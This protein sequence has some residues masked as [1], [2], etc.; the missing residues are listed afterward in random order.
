MVDE[1]EAVAK[2]CRNLNHS[3]LGSLILRLELVSRR[4]VARL[5]GIL[6]EHGEFDAGTESQVLDG[7][8]APS[9]V[10]AAHDE[11]NWT[12]EQILR[13][14]EAVL[15][16][17]GWD[18]ICQVDCRQAEHLAEVICDCVLDCQVLLE[19]VVVLD[20]LVPPPLQVVDERACSF[21]QERLAVVLTEEV[22]AVLRSPKRAPQRVSITSFQSI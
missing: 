5:D 17:P 10:E 20:D 4:F 12:V 2:D 19:L 11:V 7:L 13:T 15:K 8:C 21:G 1:A 3:G 22:G 18:L 14:W 6:V 9:A 16:G